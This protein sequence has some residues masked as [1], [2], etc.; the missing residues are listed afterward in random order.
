MDS[1]NRLWGIRRLS[2]GS[3]AE[4]TGTPRDFLTRRRTG[5]RPA[6]GRGL[7]APDLVPVD[8]IELCFAACDVLR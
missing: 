7:G 3:I 2:P 4:R 8:E 6:R 5:A 1:G